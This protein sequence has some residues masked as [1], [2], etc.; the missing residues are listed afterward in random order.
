MTDRTPAAETAAHF[1]KYANDH[2]GD[3]SIRFSYALNSIAA[4]LVAQTEL[5]QRIEQHDIANPTDSEIAYIARI[6]RE[7]YD[8][9]YENA[10]SQFEDWDRLHAADERAANLSDLL[11]QTREKLQALE[12]IATQLAP[13]Q[14]EHNVRWLLARLRG[15]AFPEIT[16]E[17]PEPGR[18][19]SRVEAHLFK[20]GGKWKYQ[21]W[22]DYSDEREELGVDLPGVGPAGWHSDGHEMAKRALYRASNRGTSGVTILVLGSYWHLFVPNPPQGHPHWVQPD[23]PTTAEREQDSQLL[24]GKLD[25]IRAILNNDHLR[26]Y[27]KANDARAVLDR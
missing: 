7:S 10:R 5:M 21:V 9:G 27:E 6:E 15:D 12:S 24:R 2:V 11:H 8:R 13:D 19:W 23:E 17:E 4:S 1:L 14:P 16:P 22:L 3:G 20:P 26:P 18:D 25:E